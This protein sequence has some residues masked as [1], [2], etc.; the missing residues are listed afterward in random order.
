MCSHVKAAAEGFVRADEPKLVCTHI[1]VKTL[2]H[3][4]EVGAS[5][6]MAL[7]QLTRA[8]IVRLADDD[9]VIHASDVVI[10]P[11][12]DIGLY[13][14]VHGP[15]CEREGSGSML[16]VPGTVLRRDLCRRAAHTSSCWARRR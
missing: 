15:C 3:V 2:V 11:L 8:M 14:P 1:T 12:L 5:G 10:A 4:H 7:A 16:V 6:R 9:V 13:G